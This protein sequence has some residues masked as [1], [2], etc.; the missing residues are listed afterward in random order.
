[1]LTVRVCR[2]CVSWSRGG[3][4]LGVFSLAGPTSTV[5]NCPVLPHTHS[6]LLVFY[7]LRPMLVS[8]LPQTD[9]S[10]RN[11]LLSSSFR[12]LFIVLTAQLRKLP[13]TCGRHQYFVTP[14][15]SHVLHYVHSYRNIEICGNQ[16]NLNSF[17]R[18][19]I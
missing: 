17:D 18:N 1:M 5:S 11:S 19:I 9:V 8:V 13:P 14:C 10:C 4:P 15:L 2:S 3:E 6:L 16:D 7:Q 12:L